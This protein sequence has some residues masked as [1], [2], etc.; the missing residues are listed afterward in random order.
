MTIRERTLTDVDELVHLA[1]AVPISDRY[2]IH[3][4]HGDFAAFLISS[5]AIAGWVTVVDG[6]IGGHVALHIRSTPTAVD[7]AASSLQVDTTQLAFVARLLVAPTSRGRGLG[8]QLLDVAAAEAR[9]RD[10]VAVLDVVTT[11]RSAIDLYEHA[12]WTRLGAASFTL[13]DGTEI[14]EYVYAAPE[15]DD[16]AQ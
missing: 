14:A 2:P 8:R 1:R 16:R 7:L 13:S 5:E 10:L 4:P 12:R 15:H 9:H 6:S 11:A 3:V